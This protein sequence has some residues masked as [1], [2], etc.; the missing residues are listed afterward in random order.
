MT[1]P[2]IDP[3]DLIIQG[4]FHLVPWVMNIL[5]LIILATYLFGDIA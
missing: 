2:D 5:G 4:I 3:L 1:D